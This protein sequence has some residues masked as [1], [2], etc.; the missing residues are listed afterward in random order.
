MSEHRRGDLGEEVG[1]HNHR[2][3]VHTHIGHILTPHLMPTFV[4][5]VYVYV[6]VYIICVCIYRCVCV[7]V[8]V[9]VC[10]TSN[11]AVIEP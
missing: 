2:R 3:D 9:C 4:I 5:Y 8:C 6:Y 11:R 10:D 7:C 1:A